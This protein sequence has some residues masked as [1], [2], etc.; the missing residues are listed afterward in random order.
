MEFLLP[1]SMPEWLICLT[2]RIRFLMGEE[3]GLRTKKANKTAESVI[4]AP[5]PIAISSVPY[6]SVLGKTTHRVNSRIG[7]KSYVGWGIR[8]YGWTK[9][10]IYKVSMS[11]A[12]WTKPHLRVPNL[13]YFFFLED[14]A[15][16]SR[17]CVVFR[18]KWKWSIH[19][20]AENTR[21]ID[22]TVHS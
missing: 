9:A 20:K 7:P 21:S 19:H 2:H 10:P 13:S 3:S 5:S 17:Y 15:I 22:V 14:K 1:G 4:A 11:W 18:S 16:P 6:L 12:S 8:N